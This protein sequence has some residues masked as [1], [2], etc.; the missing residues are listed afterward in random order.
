MKVDPRSSDEI[1]EAYEELREAV[2]S[3][4]VR[5]SQGYILQGQV[6]IVQT[7]VQNKR[8]EKVGMETLIL[9]R[10]SRIQEDQNGH[11][12]PSPLESHPTA[13]GR[14]S[15][16]E[17]IGAKHILAMRNQ[18]GVAIRKLFL[19]RMPQRRGGILARFLPGKE[20]PSPLLAYYE[21]A[22]AATP[23][24]RVISAFYR[25]MDLDSHQ[26]TQK[27]SGERAILKGEELMERSGI[28]FS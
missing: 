12:E 5:E 9:V 22:A 23:D 11:G 28:A 24:G 18:G 7:V 20:E 13:R 27:L 8:G 17:A 25:E 6:P 2:R 1:L 21:V 14:S 10:G 15:P 3:R 19:R 26:F 16:L 4:G